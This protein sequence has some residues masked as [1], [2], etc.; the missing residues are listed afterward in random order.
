MYHLH[1]IHLT[2]AHLN[3]GSNL[4]SKWPTPHKSTLN[5][6]CWSAV[7]KISHTKKEVF[8]NRQNQEAHTSVNWLTFSNNFLGR[9]VQQKRPPYTLFITNWNIS[10]IESVLKYV[11]HNSSLWFNIRRF[12]SF[13]NICEKKTLNI[14][15]VTL[16]RPSRSPGWSPPF[17]RS[18]C[19]PSPRT[20]LPWKGSSVHFKFLTSCSF[21]ISWLLI[22]L[23]IRLRNTCS[24][25]GDRASRSPLMVF[26][27]HEFLLGG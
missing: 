8:Y 1:P 18:W 21:E 20:D 26:L 14:M 19:R 12:I 4:V 6:K 13:L 11:I 7:A 25:L 3:L 24:P 16:A 9:E 2:F 15:I 23:T 5:S 22:D 10:K 27:T 17:G